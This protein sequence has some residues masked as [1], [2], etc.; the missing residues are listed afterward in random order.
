LK[1][2]ITHV[3]GPMNITLIGYRCSGKTTVGKFLSKELG[4]D[5][6]DMD[7]EIEKDTK[8]SIDTI[9][10]RKGWDYFRGL[11]K[12][13]VDRLSKRDRT[14]IATGG[15]VVLDRGNV[16]KLKQNSV[17][18]WLR[19][20]ADVLRARMSKE[21][22]SGRMRPSLTGDN[23]FEEIDKVLDIR[24][25]LYQEAATLVVDTDDLSV[26]EITTSIKNAALVGLKG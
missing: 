26:R 10:S 9:I 6:I 17:I 21:L 19:G 13:L 25:P 8:C 24:T 16:R 22:R 2:I 7:I 12:K 1:G 11:E 15:G 14:V 23:P 4:M 20:S 18:I 3:G 5:F